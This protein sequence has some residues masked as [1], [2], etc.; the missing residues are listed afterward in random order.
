MEEYVNLA[1]RICV[2]R[3]ATSETWQELEAA[4]AR[5]LT[6]LPPLGQTVRTPQELAVV[7]AD[8][9]AS[10]SELAVQLQLLSQGVARRTS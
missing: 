10:E 5:A 2:M 4:H 1:R 6:A 3:D 9:F 8:V 7:P